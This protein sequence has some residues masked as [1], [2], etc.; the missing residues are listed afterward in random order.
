MTLSEPYRKSKNRSRVSYRPSESI[1][2]KRPCCK[3]K[4]ILLILNIK[5]GNRMKILYVTWFS[6]LLLVISLSF[7]NSD[8]L[9]ENYKL[10]SSIPLHTDSKAEIRDVKTTKICTNGCN[11]NLALFGIIGEFGNHKLHISFNVNKL[12]V[13]A[14]VLHLIL[15]GIYSF[16]FFIHYTR[17]LF[18]QKILPCA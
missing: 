18:C 15:K 9:Q 3:N 5:N 11:D 1:N 4:Q 6:F 10:L 2:S 16:K 13:W 8:K 14:G 7:W 17:V 12:A